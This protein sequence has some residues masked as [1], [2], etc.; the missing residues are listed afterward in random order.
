MV[1][2]GGDDDVDRGTRLHWMDSQ[3]GLDDSVTAPYTP[4]V[5]EQV[6]NGAVRVS[7]HE[8]KNEHVQLTNK[9]CSLLAKLRGTGNGTRHRHNKQQRT[10]LG[11]AFKCLS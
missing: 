8:K 9:P 10:R 4:L 5:V 7:T 2:H 6:D 11:V 1:E 3:A